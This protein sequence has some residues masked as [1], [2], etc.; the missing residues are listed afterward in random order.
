MA[1]SSFT[2]RFVISDPEEARKFLE[3]ANATEWEPYKQKGLVINK[4]ES[5]EVAER[6]KRCL[7][8]KKQI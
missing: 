8:S 6:F 7:Q 4:K 1:T 2:E 5:K 3:I